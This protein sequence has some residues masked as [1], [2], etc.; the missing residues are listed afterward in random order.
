MQR[1]TR[2]NSIGC[3][4]KENGTATRLPYGYRLQPLPAI[5]LDPAVAAGLTAPSDPRYSY[6]LAAIALA[7]LLIAC[8]NFTLLAIGRSAGRA[9]EVGVRKAIGA[10]R[11]Q[12][13][14]QFWGE[15]ILLSLLALVLGL[16][17]AELFLPTFNTLAAKDLHFDY[18]Q[19]AATVGALIGLMLL[20][21]VLAGS[22]PALV[23]SGFK[24][25][26]SLRQR[27]RLKGSNPL[28]RS[29][30]VVQFALSVFLIV[31]T[32][33]M[34][35]Q[36]D[37][38]QTKNLG[39]D[40][41]HVV[42]IPTNGLPGDE[43]LARFRTALGPRRDVLGVTGMNNAP[44]HGWSREGW[45]YKGEDKVAYTYRVESDFLDVMG[46]DLVAG[47][48][49]D[50]SRST[51]STGA[52]LV[53]EAFVRDF[54][55]A[56]PL[57]QRLDGFYAEP[58]VVGVVRDLHLLPLRQA[59]EP[60]VLTMDPGWGMGHLLVRIAP[61]DLSTTLAALEATWNGV[62]LATPFQYSFL[63][64]DLAKQYE[65]ERRWSRIVGYGALFAVLVA[66]LGL[67]GL[68][69]LTVVQRT[70]EI[71]IRKA[72]GATA[73]NIAALLSKDF[74]VLVLVGVVIAAPLAYLAAERWLEGFAYR[75]DLGPGVFVLAG[76]TA[77][78]IALVTVS[79]HA[80]RA[81]TADP[82]QS[83]RYE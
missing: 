3:G 53:N 12:L 32:L 70:K 42:V 27:M 38:V 57:G 33:V 35:R 21:G 5:H 43:L 49:F 8:I 28:T 58:E 41:E 73:T 75:I 52:V 48:N 45:D 1:I 67:F 37:Y 79:A 46:V 47:R 56:E 25:V 68:A 7:I 15:S 69:S 4:P 77:L 50:P 72:L 20:V 6:I 80:L 40:E 24:P 22:Y 31:G 23:L 81:A 13:L 63:D 66:C 82:V 16:S 44:A 14:F 36:L 54:G 30:V 39:F 61:D 18:L 55:W 51:D 2:T 10:R 83:L 29:L 60:M 64:D 78:V 76:G 74:V 62:A 19:N 26:E 34:L 59:V 65:S 9:R 71:G 11:H 17:L